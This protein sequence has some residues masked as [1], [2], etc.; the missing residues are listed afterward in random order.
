MPELRYTL[1]AD[2]TSDRALLPHLTWLLRQRLPEYAIQSEMAELWRMPR[3]PKGLT[4]RIQAAFELYPCDL[5]F[6]HRDAERDPRQVRVEEIGRAMAEVGQSPPPTVCVIPVRMQEAWLLFDEFAI[7]SA[8][9][10]PRGRQSL[11]LPALPSI[12]NHPDPKHEL[13]ELLKTASGLGSRRL[14]AFSPHKAAILVSANIDD[15]SPLRTVPA[16]RLLEA[17]LDQEVSQQGW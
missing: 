2:G 17:D 7:R 11:T 12:E 15:F 6:V 3:R 4:Q 5:L 16:F 10:N 9:G 8:A 13:H 14:S 1:L